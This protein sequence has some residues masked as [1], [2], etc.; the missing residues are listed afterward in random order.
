[1]TTQELKPLFVEQESGN[2]L[3]SNPVTIDQLCDITSDLLAQH[4]EL[5]EALTSPAKSFGFLQAKL[6]LME[7]EVFGCLFLNSQHQVLAYEDLFKGTIDAASV[8]PRE[9]VKRVLH[10]NAAAVILCHNHPSGT[11]E[12][13]QA[14]RAITNKLKEALSLVDVSVLDHVVIGGS[15]QVSFAERG[16]I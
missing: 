13:S 15:E 14:D 11:P 4:F 16:L 1:M 6:A 7:H 12:P 8:Y 5:G 3:I 2:Y 9:V 10:H